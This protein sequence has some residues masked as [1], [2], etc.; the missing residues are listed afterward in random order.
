[1]FK[2]HVKLWGCMGYQAT[3][4]IP[5][6]TVNFDTENIVY[7]PVIPGLSLVSPTRI[8]VSPILY[9]IFR[10]LRVQRSDES[11]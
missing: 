11:I 7:Y 10:S 1:M 2:F 9:R 6:I 5:S 4:I 8:F 3:K